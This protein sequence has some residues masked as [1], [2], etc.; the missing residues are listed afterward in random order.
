[1]NEPARPLPRLDLRELEA[2]A[3]RAL[4]EDLGEEGDITSKRIIR[5][6]QPARG[7]IVAKSPGVLAGGP[8]A[9]AVFHF[10]DKGLAILWFASDG[11]LLEP[12]QEVAA[13]SGRAR[14][15]LAAERVALNFL[16]HLSGVA[17]LTAQ[18]V[19]RCSPH[20]V[21][22]LCTRKTLPGLRAV[23]R[24]AVAV[25][26]GQLHRA[27]LFDAIL[28][29]ANHTRLSGGL[30]EAVRRVK[31]AIRAREIDA[32]V[33][34]ASLEE[35]QEALAAG[36]DRILLD[37]AGPEIIGEAV[38]A[39]RGRA[40]LEVSGGLTLDNVEAVARL[41]PDAVSVGAITHSVPALD[42][43]LTILGPAGA[44]PR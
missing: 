19:E 20:G 40:F 11:D 33:E 24:Y 4:A 16:Q 43:A 14:A 23:Q 2:L 41:G 26:G 10:V 35:L 5:T 21:Q 9:E 39:T 27:G 6:E 8:V 44:G 18:F 1:M 32:E 7:R 25:G 38:R 28:I 31:T 37:N 13:L 15:M 3:R 34:V 12:R 29:K 17:T 22:V 30:A 42:L 36:V